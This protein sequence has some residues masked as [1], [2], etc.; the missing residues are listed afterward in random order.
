ML[1]PSG[2]LL[3]FATVLLQI[4]VFLQPLLPAQY[5]IAPVC[6]LIAQVSRSRLSLQDS[7]AQAEQEQPHQTRSHHQTNPTTQSVSSDGHQH[8]SAD[9]PHHD[10]NHQCQYCTIYG[11]LLLP[12]SF[13]LKEILVRVQVRLLAFSQNFKH[14]YFE[15]Q[16]LYLLPQG[17]A[18]PSA[19]QLFVI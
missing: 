15:L 11:N 1:K 6:E 17:R 8:H 9:H 16:R 12:P 7:I 14:V 18:P 10:L 2:M 5:Q 3:A 4:A 13:D 19:L